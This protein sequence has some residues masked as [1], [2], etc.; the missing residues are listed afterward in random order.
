V[1]ERMASSF[2][3]DVREVVCEASDPD[4]GYFQIWKYWEAEHAAM[5][6]DLAHCDP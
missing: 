2:A 1:V 4:P 3:F 5:T 6:Y